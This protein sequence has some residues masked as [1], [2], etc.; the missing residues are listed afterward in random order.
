VTIGDPGNTPDPATGYGAVGYAY[1]I[2]TFDITSAQYCAF[3]NCVAQADPYSVYNLSMSPGNN[4]ASC[5][6]TRLGTPAAYTY[7]VDSVHAN[8]PLNS[9][10]WADAARFCN[11]LE[12]G[13]PITGG[14]SSTTTED[15]SYAL[16]GGQGNQLSSIVRS[17]NA[18]YVIPSENEWYK[19]AYYDPKGGYF[20]YPTQ[21]NSPPSNV[22]SISGTNNANFE[23]PNL[24]F[25]DPTTYI[26][27]VGTFQG[28]SGPWGTFDQG[29]DVG[30]L[31][32][33]PGS[34]IE[35]RG[36]GYDTG[37]SELKSSVQFPDKVPFIGTDTGFRIAEVPE[38]NSIALITIAALGLLRRRRRCSP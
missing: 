6:I 7:T 24:G 13:Q 21:S 9:V 37:V 4:G 20:I 26:T 33:D 31:I 35:G 16:N 28:S 18:I 19:A 15:G 22:L 5:G 14:E 38:P 30:Q 8:L 3:L 12:N 2:G 36:G 25:T 29:G 11:W 10:S 32:G 17:P 23:D 34:G 1:Q 27:P